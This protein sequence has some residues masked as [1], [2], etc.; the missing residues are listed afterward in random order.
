MYMPTE[1]DPN[2]LSLSCCHEVDDFGEIVLAKGLVHSVDP[3]NTDFLQ[4]SSL[5][6]LPSCRR[7]TANK[8][9]LLNQSLEELLLPKPT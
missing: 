6:L 4:L 1:S 8:Q 5:R 3:A 7:R 2:P 9:G